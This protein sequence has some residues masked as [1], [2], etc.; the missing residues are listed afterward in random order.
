MSI[1]YANAQFMKNDAIYLAAELSIGNYYGAD[2]SLNYVYK[3]TYSFKAGLTI[4]TRNSKTTPNDYSSGLMQIFTLGLSNPTDQIENYQIGVG[5]IYKLNKKGTIR[6]NITLGLGY[7]VIIEP[8]NWKYID[9][10]FLE[11]NYTWNYKKNN[12]VSLI[13]NPKIEFPIAKFMGLSISPTI[14]IN[15]DRTYYGIG[16][17]SMLGKV[18][19]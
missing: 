16:I 8:E 14:Q 5:K 18:K 9:N 10:S 7:T 17:G 13:I 12:T 4:N 6:A 3:N 2:I 11:E 19:N 1:N 15:K